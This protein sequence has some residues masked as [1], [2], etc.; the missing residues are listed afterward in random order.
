MTATSNSKDTQNS[1]TVYQQPSDNE[2]PKSSIVHIEGAISLFKIMVPPKDINPEDD[3]PIDIIISDFFEGIRS[4]ED[5]KKISQRIRSEKDEKK[6]RYLKNTAPCVRIRGRFATRKDNSILSYSSF[7]DVDI[8][9]LGPETDDIKEMLQRDPYTYAI[10]KT[11]RGEGLCVII[12]IMP[13]RWDEMWEGIKRYYLKTYGLVV[14]KSTGNVGRNR[15]ISHDPTI[16]TNYHARLFKEY[17]PASEK[18]AAQRPIG[19]FV[20]TGRDID[21]LM[22]Q[23]SKNSIDLT[24]NYDDWYKSG[25]ALISEF[26]ESA[27]E[28]FHRISQFHPE[29][30]PAD[31]DRKFN[32]LIKENPRRITIAYFYAR[33]KAAGLEWMTSETRNIVRL[34]EM[35]KKGHVKEASAVDEIVKMEG[36]DRAEAESIVGQVYRAKESFDTGDCLL[37][38]LELFLKTNYP[39]RYNEIRRDFEDDDGKPLEDHHYYAMYL[40]AKKVLGDKIR[41]EDMFKMIHSR[42][43]Y[44][45]FHPFLSFFQHHRGMKPVGV[46]KALA[47]TIDSD[48]CFAGNEFNPDYVYTFLRKWLVGII[49]S[50]FGEPCDLV[51]VLTGADGIGKT[52]FFRYI[53]PD[54]WKPYFLESKWMPGKDEDV[55]MCKNLIAFNDE[56]KGRDSKDMEYFKA[57]TSKEFF[58][59][60]EVYTRKSV[61]LRRLAVLCATSNHKG[62]INE[63][64]FNRRIIPINVIS[65]DHKAYNAIDKTD[66]IMEAYHAYQAGERPILT[67]EQ[68]KM[69]NDHTEEFQ[70]KS[71]ERQLIERFMSVPKGNGGEI[72]QFMSTIEILKTLEVQINN[73][74]LDDRK[75]GRELQACGFIRKQKRNPNVSNRREWG[76]DVVWQE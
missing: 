22:E 24:E 61:K 56:F 13:Q 73:R 66:L 25:W 9:G 1:E 70:N 42:T 60:R 18:K 74:K 71:V 46:I 43:L 68:R 50:I 16:F 47:D 28:Y 34:A 65:I 67:K 7:F 49:G 6:Q 23:V 44:P 19:A 30:N 54:E 12:R 53:L 39:I 63:P 75:L 14:D 35:R 45:V 52:W 51:P 72:I 76:Y 27:R 21:H 41:Y 26:G 29:Y 8:D 4:G 15:V 2:R 5:W 57:L 38:Q 48:T 3:Y 55:D 36:V 20:H 58:S 62:V 37:D 33:C 17:V 64:E 69:L 32:Y 40:H 11:V 10:F 59:V 31:C